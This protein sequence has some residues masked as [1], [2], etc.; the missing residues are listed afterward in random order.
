MADLMI[1]LE[2]W[3]LKASAAIRSIGAVY[4]DFKSEK[5]GGSFYANVT[6]DSLESMDF[7]I[8]PKTQEWWSTQS[9]AAQDI[10]KQDPLHIVT[11]LETFIQWIKR[12]GQPLDELRVWSHGASFDITILTTAFQYVGFKEPW[13]HRNIRDTRTLIWTAEALGDAV[14][15][16]T[17]DGTPHNALDDARH[18][19]L[20]MIN[21]MRS[22][23]GH[24][25][26]PSRAGDGGENLPRS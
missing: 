12:T 8:D 4:F 9:K 16:P 24:Y 17:F 19:A 21:V 2:T 15:W 18:Q 20:H 10:F 6:D 26:Q 22:I 13:G 14:E 1:D 25:Q 5:L 3:S 11:A 23:R 7:H